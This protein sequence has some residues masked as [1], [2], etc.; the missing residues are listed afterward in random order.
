M[1]DRPHSRRRPPQSSARI[2][3]SPWQQ[4]PSKATD[5]D[6]SESAVRAVV[7]MLTRRKATMGRGVN[8]RA[9]AK[10]SDTHSIRFQSISG[11]AMKASNAASELLEE[12]MNAR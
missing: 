5:S 3:A 9:N 12:V 7:E 11:R 2:A 1:G 4:V 6:T 8:R 10:C